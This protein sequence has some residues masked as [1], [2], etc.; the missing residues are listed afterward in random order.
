MG[1]IEM[2][3]GSRSIQF[4]GLFSGLALTLAL[5]CPAGAGATGP[6]YGY[7]YTYDALGRL[8]TVTNADGS[9]V[10]Y[11]YD[12][13]GNRTQYVSTAAT[14]AA[15]V[16]NPVGIA[17]SYNTGATV[18]TLNIGGTYNAVGASSAM[19]GVTAVNGATITYQPNPGY[20][21]GDSFSYTAING[22]AVSNAAVVSVTINPLVA[23]IG[24]GASESGAASAHTF[25]AN[26]ASVTGGSGS[27]SYLWTNTPDSVGTW[28]TGGT[29]VAFAPHVSNVAVTT[30]CVSSA[31]HWVTVTDTS[32]HATAVS[33]S[34]VYTWR[35]LN[36]SCPP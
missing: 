16:A 21:G 11:S 4:Q 22:A 33:N 17:V 6:A 18:V 35:N 15:P 24:P 25:A 14:N 7:A 1:M 19:H 29:G 26:T 20:V 10:T 28:T 3:I 36:K 8:G 12:A 32:T 27:Y 2:P 31:T 5:F 9:V 34:V 30:I 13:A 23:T